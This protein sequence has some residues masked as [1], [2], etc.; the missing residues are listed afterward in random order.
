MLTCFVVLDEDAAV[1]VGIGKGATWREVLGFSSSVYTV[2]RSAGF[3]TLCLHCLQRSAGFLTLCVHCVQRGA[4]FL[5]LCLH[6]V[7]R[8]A[9]FLILCFYCLQ[10]SAGFLTLCLHCAEK[11]WVSHSLFST[12]T[13]SAVSTESV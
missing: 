12:L 9:G 4:G 8:S 11:C 5:I 6:C 13:L 7:Q 1:V 2:Q 10:R 3:L